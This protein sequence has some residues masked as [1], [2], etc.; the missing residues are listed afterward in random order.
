LTVG[1][2]Y[3]TNDSDLALEYVGLAQV[4]IDRGIR[5][6]MV[7]REVGREH[8]LLTLGEADAEASGGFTPVADHVERGLRGDM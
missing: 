3:F 1:E 4:R 6:V 8:L 7:F 5:L 2:F